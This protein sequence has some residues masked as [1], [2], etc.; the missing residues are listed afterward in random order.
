MIQLLQQK[1]RRRCFHNLKPL[2]VDV[3]AGKNGKQLP[4]LL[5]YGKQNLLPHILLL[6]FLE[7]LPR[8]LPI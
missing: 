3:K 8:Y 5:S 6:A 7:V 1:T 4:S 2:R